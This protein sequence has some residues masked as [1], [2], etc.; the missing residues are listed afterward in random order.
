MRTALSSCANVRFDELLTTRPLTEPSQRFKPAID[1]RR[2]ETFDR[3][4][5]LAIVDQIN[6]GDLVKPELGPT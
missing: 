3:N 6:R 2:L 5:M 4:E 1:G